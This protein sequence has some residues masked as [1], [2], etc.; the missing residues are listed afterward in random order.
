[1]VIN[2]LPLKKKANISY[3]VLA[4]GETVQNENTKGVRD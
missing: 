3:F 2:Y 1:M 4:D